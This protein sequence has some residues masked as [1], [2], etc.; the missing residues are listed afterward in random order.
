MK[1]T[2]MLIGRIFVLGLSLCLPGVVHAVRF[3]AGSSTVAP[4]AQ[5]T[6]S[7]TVSGFTDVNAFQFSLRWDPNVLRFESTGSSGLPNMGSAFDDSQKT[8]GRLGVLWEPGDGGSRTVSDGTTIFS[9]TF[10]ALGS[11]GQSSSVSFGDSPTRKV[12]VN[13]ATGSFSQSD[14]SIQI[15]KVKQNQTITFGSLNNKAY[16]DG[17]FSVSATASSGLPVSF[18]IASGPATVSGSTV[19][20]TGV[21]TVTVRASRAENDDYN[22]ATPVDQSFTVA[23]TGQTITFGSLGIKYYGD[24]PFTVSAT[25][26]SGLTVSFSIVSGPA[27][28]SGSTVTI[29]GVGTVT[30]KAA[31]A[32]D[33]NYNAAPDAQQ[34][35]T[36]AKGNQTITFGALSNKT[37]GNSSFSVS[38]T[39]SSGL[40][41][42]FSIASGP[43]TI[44]GNTVTITGAGTVIVR[45]NQTGND[46]YNAAT[47]VDQSFTVSKANQSITFGALSNRTYGEA[48]LN[49][50]ATASSGLTVSLSLVSGPATFAGNTLTIAGA[51]PVTV[52]A[53]QAGNDNYNAA[54]NVEQSFNVA[55]ADQTISFGTLS[56]K[57]YGDA[58]FSVSATGSS[59]LAVSFS[60]VSGPATVSGNTVTLTG[61]GTVIVRANQTGND[62]YNAATPV[63]QSFT[64]AKGNQTITFG[65]LSNKTYGDSPFSVSAT[66]SSGLTVS[67]SLVSGPATLAGNTVTI[68]GVGTVALR[69]SQVG[70]ANYNAAPDVE[71]S[72]AVAK[73]NQTVSFGALASVAF[74]GSPINLSATASSGLPVTFSVVSGPATIAGNTLT[75]TGV[76]TA[77]VRASQVGND[78]YNAAAA[79][80][81]SLTVAKATPPINWST[82]AAITYGAALSS[83]QL[84]ATANIPGTYTYSPPSG[85]TLNAGSHTLSVSFTPNDTANYNNA[86]ASVTLQVQKATPAINW[87]SPASIAYGTALGGAQLNAS[88]SVGGTFSYSPP[89]GTILD[90]GNPSL[91]VSFT[92]N[93][94]ANY[95]NASATVS[96][97]VSKADQTINFASLPQ[98]RRGESF[99]LS[100]ST[101]SGL[102]VSF[103]VSG[104]ATLTGNTVTLNGPGTV[105]V[106]A[107]QPGN[108]NYN[109]AA[110]VQRQFNVIGNTPPTLELVAARTIDEGSTL[111]E[112]FRA[113]DSDVPTQILT[114]RLEGEPAGASVNPS[115]GAFTW[116]PTES[117]GPGA[118]NFTVRVTDNGD[119][120]ENAARTFSITVNEVNVAPAISQIPGQTVKAGKKLT[121]TATASDTDVPANTLTFSLGSDAPTGATINPATGVFEWTPAESLEEKT[122]TFTVRVTDN[123]TPSLSASQSVTVKV[124]PTNRP[125]VFETIS[126]QTIPEGSPFTLTFKATDPDANFFFFNL[127]SGALPGMNL[128]PAVGELTWTP[129]E[130][131]GPGTYKVSVKATDDG[132]PI[133][134]A[135]IE[136]TLVVTE[137][138]TAPVL[139]PISDRTVRVGE[140]LNL[141][142]SANDSDLPANT[143]TFRLGA[144]APAGAALAATTGAFTWTP[145][146]P[147]GGTTH[148]ITVEVVDDGT[149]ALTASRSFKVAVGVSNEAPVLPPIVNQTI[150]EGSTLTLAVTASDP[151]N[152]LLTYALG[153]GAPSGMTVD[154]ATGTIRWTPEES[155]GPGSY[156][157]TVEATDNG[158]PP[159]K[160]SMSFNVLVTE[161]N[162]APV[163]AALTDQTIARG[164]TATFTPA[165]TDNDL[166]RQTLTFTLA[167]GAPEGARID[168]VT[169]AFTWTPSAIQ[170]PGNYSITVRVTDNGTPPLSDSKSLTVVVRAP[171]VVNPTLSAIS[172]Q[173]T[174]E[175]I[176]TPAIVFTVNDP[177][178]LP[179]DLKLSAS[180]SNANLVPTA[181][182]VFGGAGANR[183][184]TV[185]PAPNRVGAA[186]ITILVE[187][188][189][190][191]K[192]TTTFELTVTPA[193]PTITKQP[194]SRIVPSG[195]NVTLVVTAN[196]RGPLSYQWRFNG[197]DIAGATNPSLVLTSV[198]P[199]Q[200]GEYLAAVSNAGGSV[201]SSAATLQVIVPVTITKQPE[202]QSV[203]AGVSVTFSVEA[204]GTGPLVYQWQFNGADLAGQTNPTLQIRNA[205]LTN[206]GEYSVIVS[207]AA[208]PVASSKAKLS[209]ALPPT[210]TRQPQSQNV[211]AG[212]AVPLTVAVSGTEPLRYQWRRNNSD[213]A[214]ATSPTLA[215]SNVAVANAGEYA[216]VVSNAA[217]SVTSE[218]ARVTVT[219]AAQ[220]T[221]QPASETITAGQSA[222]LSVVATGTAPLT[223]QWRR[224]GVDLPEANQATLALANV[225]LA[226]AGNYQVIVS[227]AAGPVTSAG[228][229]LTVN[230][231]V[232]VVEQPQS[233]TVREGERVVLSVVAAGSNPITYQWQ[234]NG[235]NLA[236][237]TGPSLTLASARTS[238]AGTYRVVVRNV[239]GAVN[240]TD[241]VVRVIVPPS[242]Q[243][244]PVNQNVPPGA[245]VTF[246]VGANGDAPLEFQWKKN[247][248]NISG[249][250]G[251]SLALNN[252]QVA[253]AGNYSVV[254]ANAGGAVTSAGASLT[255]IL[256]QETGG[257]SAQQARD[258]GEVLEATFDGGSIDSGG[259]GPQT[260]KN[261]PPSTGGERWFSWKA[262]LTGIATFNTIGSTFDTVL[263]IYTGVSPNLTEVVSDDDRGGFFASQASFNAVPGTTYL[264]NVKGFGGATGRIV[265]GFKLTPTAQKLPVILVQPRSRTVTEA[266]D[267]TFDVQAQGTDLRYQWHFNGKPIPGATSPNRTL[268]AVLAEDVGICA[269]RV[270]SGPDPSALTV[271]S[272]LAALQVGTETISAQ[273]KFK[274]APRVGVSG[275]RLA[276]LG[277]QSLLQPAPDF[278]ARQFSG[279]LAF[280]TIGSGKEQGE[281]NHADD[282]GGA[283]QWVTYQA[284]ASGALRVSTEGSDFD[285][286]LAVYSGSGADFASL[287]T[288]ASDNNSGAD[289][290][291]S[292]V[293]VPVTNG[294]V[295]YIAVDGVK[296]ASGIARL[297][298][299][300]GQGPLI[301]RQ[302]LNQSVAVGAGV[303]F[304]VETTNALSSVTTTLPT[305]RY[306]WTRD[307]LKLNGETNR[308]LAI[309]SA[310]P[311]DAGD[312]AVIV[313]SFAGSATSAVAKLTVNVPLTITSQPQSQSVQAGGKATFTVT[314]S[315][316]EPISYQWRFN[317][318]DIS[319]ATNASYAINNAQS[320]T[321]GAY[322][323]IARNAIGTVQSST[324]TLTV[325]QAPSITQPPDGLEVIP[326]QRVVFNVTATGT[327]PL[328]YQWRFNGVN[329]PGATGASL[330]L[331]SIKLSDAGEYS[332]EVS[333]ESGFVLST[334]ALL[335]V[336]L[337]PKFVVQPISQTVSAGSSVVFNALATGSGTITYQ[338][339]F[340]GREIPGATNPNYEIGSARAE[341]AGNYSV[342]ARSAAGLIESESARLTVE[343]VG[344]PEPQAALIT[345]MR[346]DPATG[347]QFRLT[348]PEGR[349]ASIQVSADLVNWVD[350]K[351]EQFTGSADILDPQS[352]ALGMRFYRIIVQ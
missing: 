56:G 137:V 35:F 10:T 332:V 209:V 38:A 109:A 255:L 241:A 285:T 119:P 247:G 62:N 183:T 239:V 259:I 240:S 249:T 36:V 127:V 161:V 298:Y 214:G 152:N 27:T 110:E 76:G 136:V 300:L 121:F 158:T 217:G 305:L 339:K 41:V 288:E 132:T 135:T 13:L 120:I 254:V 201:T 297:S 347:F 191:G 20:I 40:T 343:A 143:L 154:P 296:G 342:T 251:P 168:P 148:D 85:A 283:S 258:I 12:I 194:E 123:G 314:V 68:T 311:A 192:A 54:A 292:V 341:H 64:V 233:Q 268:P 122:V 178:G 101:S 94:T 269:V 336:N 280:S 43:A 126:T 71:Q 242:I 144:G 188:L 225:Q 69:A 80:D 8:S 293:N 199:E 307:G 295:Y 248:V 115:T 157:I 351:P 323:V 177:D 32:G 159:L 31:Q 278:V 185:T 264:I 90:A 2:P 315:G 29:T 111:T 202:S 48:P 77:V 92:P 106:T 156:S 130:A 257:P 190:G 309:L 33:S 322:L 107:S 329:I 34:S 252:V 195:A 139:A 319:G 129:T 89:G 340:N 250:A 4:A 166:P 22:A 25:A 224:N 198:T 197:R 281:P 303:G 16:G 227:N 57:A 55:K 299:E 328:R 42:S 1:N 93:D 96:I 286:V 215:L 301:S 352:P 45:A 150:A 82:P 141:T 138:N 51:G 274:N 46:N 326:G 23:K 228:A 19:T 88:A 87:S 318:T 279:W 261:S 24:T 174:K 265:V 345:D 58:S 171:P 221:T 15:V 83:A 133:Q 182:I 306:Q 277:L 304:F 164:E 176:A 232:T 72:F 18:S 17:P 189:T 74:G 243:T 114:F 180:S 266:T 5:V 216:V 338:W 79:V 70:N 333:N 271:D 172:D 208:G 44:S 142:A 187:D 320:A 238:D 49:L 124:A 316:S 344:A 97:N 65:A 169:G 173:T 273:D 350:F 220:I 260:R 262:S 291:D 210:I 146:P 52:R 349:R 163:L 78:N 73:A 205:A 206:T 229:T 145:T 112:T 140:S 9:V 39:A 6:V 312:Y 223:Y 200:S 84:N 61:V 335:S 284:P 162:T 346:F 196:G 30:V 308:S 212:S 222:T 321:A 325:G 86:T 7:V 263:A 331:A 167:S 147:Q 234:R 102:A 63:D 204:T 256:P 11:N 100:A 21:G 26:S 334:P 81:Q 117:Q 310:Q 37:Y 125:P 327:G 245:S 294:A 153:A 181:N 219:Q 155:Q 175:G 203:A 50:G 289:G 103:H 75:I 270:S 28:L 99:T 313:S 184:V 47:P 330:E 246:S 231:P 236:G 128:D 131:Q 211:L 317:G 276:N 95:N 213:L 105:T 134:T 160:A 104:P 149:P 235:A 98:R 226:Q 118:Y 116:T 230:V 53:T 348:V 59:G 186:T 60:L 3:S 290:L 108:S 66:A 272:A 237:A 67:L 267:V 324:A 337:Q 91:S 287:K 179:T 253:D 170:P 151:N 165:A 113:T 275:A 218:I 302:P 14:G 282:F 207:N 193:P 244:Q